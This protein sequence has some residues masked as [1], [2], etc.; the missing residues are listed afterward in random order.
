VSLM[1]R[2]F[3]SNEM[4]LRREGTMGGTYCQAPFI[5][6]WYIFSVR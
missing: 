3:G 6:Y 5:A 2:S 4:I 1:G